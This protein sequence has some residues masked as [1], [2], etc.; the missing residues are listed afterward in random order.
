MSKDKVL[1]KTCLSITIRGIA[2]E[3]TREDG[4]FDGVEGCRFSTGQIRGFDTFV[5]GAN[6]A[7]GRVR[8][9]ELVEAEFNAGRLSDED[10][11]GK[12]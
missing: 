1:S 5:F 4:V 12:R 6:P 9:T 11:K 3:V 8:F 2:I 7:Q 10:L